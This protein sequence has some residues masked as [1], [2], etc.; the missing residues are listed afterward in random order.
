MSRAVAEVGS[1]VVA[2]TDFVLAFVGAFAVAY[3]VL[4]FA[5]AIA[6]SPVPGLVPN[7]AF[8]LAFGASFPLVAG[9]WSIARLYEVLA[10]AVAAA[11]LGTIA[12]TGLAT[13]L[14]LGALPSTSATGGWLLSLAV[15]YAVLARYDV[16]SAL[17]SG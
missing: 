9:D 15:A 4:S 17:N 1:W 7:A 2:T 16:R 5:H 14:D 8:A 6:G 13:A 12:L 10:V 3:P 11:V